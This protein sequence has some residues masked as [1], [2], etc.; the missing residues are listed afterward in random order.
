MNAKSRQ[1]LIADL[2]RA[3]DFTPEDLQANQRGEISPH[4]KEKLSDLNKQSQRPPSS[5]LSFSPV[6]WILLLGLLV[7]GSGLGF[8]Y[9]ASTPHPVF[10]APALLSVLA[11][12]VFVIVVARMSSSQNQRYILRNLDNAPLQSEEGVVSLKNIFR[13]RYS[14][15]RPGTYIITINGRR[16]WLGHTF[17]NPWL[18]DREYK[19]FWSGASYR[20]YY[21]QTRFAVFL[22]SAELIDTPS[23]A[24]F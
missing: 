15:P 12:I 1:E 7:L 23:A 21:V 20:I 11:F 10:S 14:R 2:E 13:S 24:S 16:L 9:I 5:S 4:Q 18:A 3:I 6:F 8:L 22:L 17:D 19:G